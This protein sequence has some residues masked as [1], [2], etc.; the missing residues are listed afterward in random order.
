MN[1]S[2]LKGFLIIIL[3][4]ILKACSLQ[5]PDLYFASPESSV[6]RITRLLIDED[7]NTLAGYYY[8]DNENRD[9]AGL[10]QSGD[11]FLRREKADVTHPGGFWKYKQPFSPGFA[12]ASHF[13]ISDD[14]VK[15]NL[16]IEIDQGAGM[17]QEGRDSFLL[18]KFQKGFKLVPDNV[19]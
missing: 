14:L 15:V 4:I 5:M 19:R 3:F 16:Y 7:W 1:I 17:I 18:K 8:L 11:Y 9:L 2:S 6:D 10:L 13:Q 12:Y